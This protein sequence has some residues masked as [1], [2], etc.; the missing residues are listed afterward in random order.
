[1]QCQETCCYYVYSY[2]TSLTCFDC[3]Y[4]I[5]QVFLTPQTPTVRTTLSITIITVENMQ[6]TYTF[7][8]PWRGMKNNQAFA[9][10]TAVDMD[11]SATRCKWVQ[12]MYLTDRQRIACFHEHHV[13]MRI[14]SYSCRYHTNYLDTIENMK[15]YTTNL[16]IICCCCW[17]LV[18]YDTSFKHDCLLHNGH[19]V[20]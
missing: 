16:S 4:R 20:I 11:L 15:G 9:C 14:H 7:F 13:N 2:R 5:F 12:C 3:C 19:E 10:L 6:Q 18:K 17:Y 8:F 1:M